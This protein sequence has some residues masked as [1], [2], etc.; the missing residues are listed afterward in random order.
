MFQIFKNKNRAHQKEPNSC[1]GR[2]GTKFVP[3]EDVQNLKS[4]DSDY[5]NVVDD[6]ILTKQK[7]KKKPGSSLFWCSG[8]FLCLSEK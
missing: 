3:K 1:R 2:R 6:E 8:I 5:S 4:R 7:Q